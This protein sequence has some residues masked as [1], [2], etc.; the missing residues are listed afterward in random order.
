MTCLPAM[1]AGHRV[2]RSER[3][4]GKGNLAGPCHC[5]RGASQAGG[6]DGRP[7][8]YQLSNVR[9]GRQPK[10]PPTGMGTPPENHV[11]MLGSRNSRS[12][13][14]ALHKAAE[15]CRNPADALRRYGR[16]QV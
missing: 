16:M 12:H 6:I 8:E 13:V 4:A 3:G 7:R 1:V 10:R 2:A 9:L 14:H 15:S 5:D 11:A